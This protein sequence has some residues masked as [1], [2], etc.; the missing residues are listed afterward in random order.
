MA[1]FSG[2]T[3]PENDCWIENKG[4][5]MK[6]V[7]VFKK[8]Q[9]Y[10][11]VLGARGLLTVSF[12]K[13]TKKQTELRIKRPDIQFPFYVRVPSS[14][15]S[16]YKKVFIYS[17]CNLNVKTP[18]KTIVDAGANIGLVSIYYANK[19]PE[20]KI[21]AI[22]PEESNFDIL[23]RNT[24]PYKNIHL[25][26]GALWHENTDIDLVDPGLDKWGFMTFDSDDYDTEKKF[27]HSVKGIT[28]DRIMEIHNLDS[29]DILKMDIEGAEREV[30]Q[31]PSSWIR[32]VDALIVELHE[33]LKS[34]CKRSFYNA[35]NDFDREWTDGEN[36]YLSKN[37]SCLT[38][39]DAP[40]E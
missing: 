14:D 37:T 32:K 36:I 11:N 40:D 21:V 26:Q 1:E 4:A 33:H 15:E 19:F 39:P 12:A 18:P 22:E 27:C 29:I 24:A 38:I 2:K 25:I 23:E 3:L 13:L 35:T 5:F 31:D 16:A 9:D 30:F 8:I 7:G 34:G 6:K 10:R 17:E 28:M 20:A